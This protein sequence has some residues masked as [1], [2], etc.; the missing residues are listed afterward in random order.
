MDCPA[1][2]RDTFH[3]PVVAVSMNWVLPDE[4]RDVIDPVSPSRRL[5]VELV[6]TDDDVEE[7]PGMPRMIETF[8][9]AVLPTL[10]TIR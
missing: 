6:S 2:M 8:V 7:V 3:P 5:A 4:G 1:F 9:A 10:S